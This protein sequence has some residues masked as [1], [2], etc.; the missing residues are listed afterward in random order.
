MKIC[1][2]GALGHLGSE[3]LNHIGKEHEILAIDNLSSNHHAV[4]FHR[5]L[6][7]PIQFIQED[8]LDADLP[9]LLREQ[10]IVI[11]LAA[12]TDAAHSHLHK[13]E[14][15]TVNFLGAQRVAKA[16]SE[17]GARMILPSTTSVYGVSDVLV[18]E[19]SDVK[20]QSPYAWSKLNAEHALQNTPNLR[21][22]I[23]RFGT[24]YGLSLGGRFHT[25]CQQ[26]CWNAALGRPI[27]VWKTAWNQ[28]R[29]YLWI[30]DAVSAIQHVIDK[31]L[32]DGEI[33]NVVTD[34]HAVA[35]IIAEIQRY[36]RVTV[37]YVDSEIMNQL[38]YTVSCEKFKKTGWTPMGNLRDGIAQE[39]EWL[40][41][42]NAS[43]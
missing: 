11:H 33:Y 36:R 9:L 39:M 10:D 20:P 28:Q 23:M 13:D 21:V 17:V 19:L 30:L 38:S 41:W 7:R 40:S 34:N 22:S 14:V 42:V 3:L 6:I 18:D 24:I 27:E 1:L 26:F 12:I 43:I 5:N 29:P 37:K 32:F 16:C 2:T 4:L 8:I 25:A 15:E 31:D 35:E